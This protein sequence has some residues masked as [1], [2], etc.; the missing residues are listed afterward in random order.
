[1]NLFLLDLGRTVGPAKWT[2]LRQFVKAGKALE[3]G[4][5]KKAVANLQFN[6]V[7]RDAFQRALNNSILE[8]GVAAKCDKLS[9]QTFP[10]C[11]KPDVITKVKLMFKHGIG[12]TRM[13]SINGVVEDSEGV[14][15]KAKGN[16]KATDKNVSA[17]FASNSKKVAMKG[18]YELDVA[19]GRDFGVKTSCVAK[20]DKYNCKINVGN[21]INNANLKL[22]APK[23]YLDGL[24]EIMGCKSFEEFW[25]SIPENIKKLI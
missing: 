1:M 7:E 12:N 4:T 15:A 20:G 11:Y 5:A 17:K 2:Q 14:L 24:A 10:E 22:K 9:R 13:F 16:I 23:N 6:A 3:A 18:G 19:G 25:A 21:L 8:E